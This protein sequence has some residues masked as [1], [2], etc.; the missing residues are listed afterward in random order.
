ML[1]ST[2][3]GFHSGP[4]QRFTFALL[5][6][7]DPR[8]IKYD[9]LMKDILQSTIFLTTNL[10]G[11]LFW[12]CRIRQLMGF[13]IWPTTGFTNGFLSSYFA[14]LLEKQK[15]R[16]MLALYLTNLASETLYRQLV[17]HGYLRN[18]KYGECVPFAIGLAGFISL[19]KKKQLD[20]GL[21]KILKF[22]H[23]LSEHSDVIDTSKMHPLIGRMVNWVRNS[24]GRTERCE[25]KH[26]CVSAALEGTSRN[27]ALGLGISSLLTLAR[28]F[29]SIIRRPS[30]IPRLLSSFKNF[31]L[32]LFLALM[33]FIYHVSECSLKRT[34]V[35]DNAVHFTSGALSASSMMMYPSVSI[36]MYILWKLIEIVYFKLAEQGRVPIIKHGDIILYTLSTG[37]VLGN[38]ALEPQAIRKG[39]WEFLCGL[40]GQRVRLFN[41]RLI[42]QFGF[43]SQ[44]MFD[45]FVP[46]IDPKYATINP[47][48]YLPSSPLK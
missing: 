4:T 18:Y 24:F 10:V 32:P 13:T 33:P 37:Y 26:S 21:A 11:Y 19:Y 22:T 43:D 42:T 35:P 15:R 28:S 25:H 2:D 30:Q 48:F 47:A 23:A 29:R 40:T 41:R 27:F 17:N 14:I 34:K 36:S 7:R 39:Y 8:K 20:N 3:C 5:S 6:K 38:A 9:V 16:P 45:H 12:L 31:R 46:R 1:F 44:K